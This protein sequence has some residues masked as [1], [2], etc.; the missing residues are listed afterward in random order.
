MKNR[1]LLILLL[2]YGF[3]SLF[4]Q[5]IPIGHWREHVPYRS[6]IGV[7]AAGDDIYCLTNKSLFIYNRNDGVVEYLSKLNGLSGISFSAIGYNEAQ[8][9]VVVGYDDGAIDLIK[10]SYI[11]NIP[12]IYVSS[13][14]GS[15]RVNN[16]YCK[17]NYAYLSC[18]FGVVALNLDKEEVTETYKIGLGGVQLNINDFTADET[19][20]YAATDVGVFTAPQDHLFLGFYETWKQV[21]TA[22]TTK[23]TAIEYWKDKLVYALGA[24]TYI[25]TPGT[26]E[27]DTL[28]EWN[29]GVRSMCVSRGKLLISNW[30]SLYIYYDTYKN[31]QILNKVIINGE[32]VIFDPISACF[33]DHGEYFIATRDQGLLRAQDVG[34]KA[35]NF[36]LPN[37][38][39]SSNAFSLYN[40]GKNVW[41]AAGGHTSTWAASW[42][43]AEMNSFDGATWKN[44]SVDIGNIPQDEEKIYDITTIAADPLTKK[45]YAG[46]WGSGIIELDN[47]V[48]T[49]IYNESNTGGAL[50]KRTIAPGQGELIA[51]I[52]FDSKGTMWVANSSATAILVTRT[53]DGVWSKHQV[54]GFI[55]TDVQYLMIDSYDNK[56]VVMRGGKGLIVYNEN[57]D[58]IVRR[59]AEGEGTGNIKSGIYSVAEDKNGEIWVGT[60]A[61]VY[62]IRN[63]S[64]IL[65][66][67]NGMLTAINAEQPKLLYDGHVGELLKEETVVKIVV[68]GS[69]EKWCAT[70]RNGAYKFTED[71]LTTLEHF[72]AENSPLFSDNIIDITITDNG[73]VFFATDLAVISYRDGATK[74][75]EENHNVRAFPNPVKPDYTGPIAISGVVDMAYIKITDVAGN[76]VYSTQATG[77]QAIWNAKDFKGNRVK[78][79]VYVVFITNSDGS[80]TTTTKIMVLN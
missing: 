71:G 50:Q 8:K 62:I 15:K 21:P 59:I 55:D 61:G 38:P 44:Y 45:V 51:G 73:E 39:Y 77:G 52:A 16:I 56:W 12:D 74:G 20:F 68:N 22:D 14:L 28:Y 79:G 47:G 11:I 27:R 58:A 4:A 43:A 65:D 23:C 40:D 37:G 78:S 42:K 41:V 48:V 31:P 34:K 72:T 57:S 30:Q 60:I 35:G 66:L 18:S 36:I 76:L 3:I 17:D 49:N 64:R 9:C 70:T 75:Y 25:Q 10:D 33:S 24:R 67:S 19:H 1:I 6:A 80:E 63:A 7:A 46:T 26:D 2:L 13:I 69:N 32:E 5:D 54:P 53:K 29:T